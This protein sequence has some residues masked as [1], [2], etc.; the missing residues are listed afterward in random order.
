MREVRDDM[1]INSS[2]QE[3]TNIIIPTKEAFKR[4]K[5]KGEV[6][7]AYSKE[8]PE[9]DGKVIDMFEGGDF[10]V[11][12]HEEWFKKDLTEEDFIEYANS[13]DKELRAPI[14]VDGP[15]YYKR[16]G[17]GSARDWL[18]NLKVRGDFPEEV[19]VYYVERT[20]ERDSMDDEDVE[21]SK[22]EVELW[23]LYIMIG[24]LGVLLLFYVS[25]II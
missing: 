18:E 22:D 8:I 15:K 13:C 6:L 3:N 12:F 25:F 2:Y 10:D 7:V 5:N 21:R 1:Q 9:E 17:F 19:Y 11:V 23:F 14:Y 4:L 24:L 16:A 20:Y